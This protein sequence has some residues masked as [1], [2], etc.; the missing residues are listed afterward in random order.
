[1]RVLMTT[2]AVGGVW[3]YALELARALSRRDI[4]TTLA[5]LG[6]MPSAEQVA[7]AG[8]IDGLNVQ[9]S[10][11][12][13]EWMPNPWDDVARAGEWLLQLE[14]TITPDVIHLNGYTLAS[15]PFAA[16]VVVVAH[17]CMRSWWDAVG[18]EIDRS[19][20]ARYESEVKRALPHAAVVVAPTASM[21]AEVQR[22]YGPLPCSVV[23]P[24]GRAPGQFMRG[25][26][27][28]MVIA[29][30]RLW[31]RAK[32]IGVLQAIAPELMGPVVVAREWRPGPLR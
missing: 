10:D 19:A 4:E 29:A 32:N 26:K 24:N 16:P 18:G 3:T 22:I 6:P 21:L 2:D 11:F 15:A 9:T 1:M 20:L 31:D 30:G 8:A 23:I 5:T 14:Q 27:R 17:S 28:P 25:P 7:E 13:L 12:A